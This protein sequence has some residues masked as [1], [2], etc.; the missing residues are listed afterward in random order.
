MQLVG[1]PLLGLQGSLRARPSIREAVGELLR[2]RERLRAA[3]RRRQTR[4][5]ERGRV[6][7]REGGDQER[8]GDDEPGAAVEPCVD[9]PLE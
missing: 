4:S 5:L 9:R 3:E 6:R 7:D 8:Q 1:D 2:R